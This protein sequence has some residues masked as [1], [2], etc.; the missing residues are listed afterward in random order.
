MCT[1][2]VALV[3]NTCN[4]NNSRDSACTSIFNIPYESPRIAPR[5]SSRYRDTPTSKGTFSAV[6]WPSVRPT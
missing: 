4:P 1:N 6:N 2:S 5:A 3:P